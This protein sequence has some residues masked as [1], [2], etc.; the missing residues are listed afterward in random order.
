M[1]VPALTLSLYVSVRLT[2]NPASRRAASAVSA[3]LPVQ[4]TIAMGWGPL[5]I[6]RCT[7]AS[8]LREVPARG[9]KLMTTPRRTVSL[10]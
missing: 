9:V 7:C 4:S 5:L 1:T 10:H 2:S 3:S 8:G 6:T